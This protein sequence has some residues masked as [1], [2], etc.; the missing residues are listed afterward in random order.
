MNDIFNRNNG[1]LFDENGNLNDTFLSFS[2]CIGMFTMNTSAD[3]EVISGMVPNT[4]QEVWDYIKQSD[5]ITTQEKL[6]AYIALK[7]ERRNDFAMCE[8]IYSRR[9]A[10]NLVLTL[11]AMFGAVV[12]LK[13]LGGQGTV[14]GLTSL[15]PVKIIK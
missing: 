11:A 2:R 15:L 7:E 13:M 6:K 12:L 10:N 14:N 4:F 1:S 3:F 9:K 5:D 8:K